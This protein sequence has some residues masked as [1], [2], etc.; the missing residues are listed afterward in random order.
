M[1]SVGPNRWCN[2]LTISTPASISPGD[3]SRHRPSWHAEMI[4]ERYLDKLTVRISWRKVLSVAEEMAVR[5]RLMKAVF[6][7]RV[8]SSDLAVGKRSGRGHYS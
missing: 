4:S 2:A 8:E 6:F 7:L 5:R 3:L 1:N